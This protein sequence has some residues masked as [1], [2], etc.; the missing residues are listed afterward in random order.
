MGEVTHQTLIPDGYADAH[1]RRAG[2]GEDHVHHRSQ[3]CQRL[4]IGKN[5]RLE[6]EQSDQR[7]VGLGRPQVDADLWRPGWVRGS[8]G[9]FSGAI[10]MIIWRPSSFGICSTLARSAISVFTFSRMSMA[11]C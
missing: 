11:R 9:Y 5:H 3:A 4:G 7:P 8:H 10:T 1:T 2:A 6:L